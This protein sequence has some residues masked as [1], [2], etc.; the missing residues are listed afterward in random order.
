MVSRPK[1]PTGGKAFVKGHPSLT[2]R[3]DVPLS[4][5]KAIA[6]DEHMIEC[7]FDKL[8]E[9]LEANNIFDMSSNIFNCGFVLAPEV[10]CIVGTKAVSHLT[11]DIKSQ[12]TVLVCT[13]ASGYALVPFVISIERQ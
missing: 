3:I 13:S 6:T 11:N 10:V 12:I 4:V 7:Y 8:E 2:L 1:F 5:A 9:T